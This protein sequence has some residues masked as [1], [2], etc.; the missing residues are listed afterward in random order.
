M[1]G[2]GHTESLAGLPT[3]SFSLGVGVAGTFRPGLAA[4]ASSRLFAL[5]G[6][7]IQSQAPGATLGEKVVAR[8]LNL[9]HRALPVGLCNIVRSTVTC[10]DGDTPQLVPGCGYMSRSCMIADVG[11]ENLCRGDE[12]R[13]HRAQYLHLFH[14]GH[15]AGMRRH[16]SVISRPRGSGPLVG[17]RCGVLVRITSHQCRPWA[18]FGY[19]ASCCWLGCGLDYQLSNQPVPGLDRVCTDYWSWQRH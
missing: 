1:V 16:R 8:L 6:P 14:T 3:C 9:Q 10:Q 12:A 18:S 5:V 17:R 19:K 11:G 4:F 15:G 13:E 2:T 7:P